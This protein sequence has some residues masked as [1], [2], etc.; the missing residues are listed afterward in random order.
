MNNPLRTLLPYALG[1]L[2]AG[3]IVA[4]KSPADS[5]QYDYVAIEKTGYSLYIT[6]GNEKFEEMKLKDEFKDRQHYGP[7]FKRINE[8]E[9]KGYE[10]YST[11]LVGYSSSNGTVV[12]N[13]VLM[14]KPR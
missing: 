5:K 14:R 8:Y 6:E 3:G 13:Y 1:L 9:A 11:D 10:V 12:S 7:L 4:A 2:L